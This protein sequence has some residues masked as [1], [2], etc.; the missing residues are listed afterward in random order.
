MGIQFAELF[1]DNLYFEISKHAV[2]LAL[3]LKD[4]FIKKGY[5]LF[6]D[7]YTNQQFVILSNDK[8]FELKCEFGFE[9]SQKIS[10]KESAYRFCASWATKEENIEKLIMKL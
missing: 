3:K 8:A 10:E 6:A 9:L 4:A 7:S 5:S 1:T 2:S